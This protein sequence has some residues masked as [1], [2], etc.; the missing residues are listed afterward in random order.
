MTTTGR[1]TGRTPG[2]LLPRDAICTQIARL[3]DETIRLTGDLPAGEHRL[4]VNNVVQQFV[5]D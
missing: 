4:R 5:V 3:F 1:R 2:R